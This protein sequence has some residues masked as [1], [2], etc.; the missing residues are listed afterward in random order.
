MKTNYKVFNYKIQKELGYVVADNDKQ[1][2]KMAKII[3]NESA[4]V[5]DLWSSVGGQD[6][7]RRRSQTADKN[8]F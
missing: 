2:L 7:I 6:V 3:F 4:P 8:G 1:A 5:I